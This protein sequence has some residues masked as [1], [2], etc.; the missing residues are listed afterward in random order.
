MA[1][2]LALSGSDTGS[3]PCPSQSG[4][5][6]PS[7][8]ITRDHPER[9]ILQDFIAAAFFKTYGAHV[10]NFCDILVGCKN[11]DG[12]WIAE[13]GFS[14]AKNGKTFLEQYLDAP[15]E[16]E[17]AAHEPLLTRRVQTI[18][19]DIDGEV[20][21]WGESYKLQRLLQNL[22]EN[23]SQYG[24]ENDEIQIGIRQVSESMAWITSNNG[25]SILNDEMKSIFM[26][27]YRILG[28]NAPGSGL[29]LAIV[30]EF[31]EQHHAHIE[32]RCKADG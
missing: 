4:R 11:A 21:V 28:T 20:A 15:L 30:K 29:G 17:I 8:W 23:A 2:Q 26:P 19:L 18:G 14:L 24:K 25:R 5:N 13:L 12:V 31:V 22:F 3:F 10:R 6:H 1:M 16:N 9:E 27:Y 7:D 32:M